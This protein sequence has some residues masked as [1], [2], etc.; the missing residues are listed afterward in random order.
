MIG[1]LQR[2]TYDKDQVV[3]SMIKEH[4]H[5]LEVKDAQKD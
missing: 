1:H 5:G 3:D 2:D 4:F